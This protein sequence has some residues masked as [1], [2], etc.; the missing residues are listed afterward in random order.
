MPERTISSKTFYKGRILELELQ[1]IELEPGR[2]ARREIVRHKPAV[3][4]LAQLAAGDYVLVKQFRKPVECDVL[5]IVAGLV[6]E[7]ESPAACAVREVQE[8]TGYD[9]AKLT[10]LC[11]VWPAAGYCDEVLHLYHARLASCAE[12]ALPDEDERIVPVRLTG[13]QLNALID[14]GEVKD[15]KT[16]AALLLWKRKKQAGHARRGV[17]RK[18]G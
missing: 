12:P 18:R 11:D 4:V 9:V 14:R 15:A 5:E 6:E 17:S 8:E 10:H 16:L 7:G 2:R 13:A 3:A 1:E